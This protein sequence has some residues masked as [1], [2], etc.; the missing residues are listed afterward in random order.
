MIELPRGLAREFRAVLR[1]CRTQGR[2]REPCPF[3]VCRGGAHGLT[4]TCEAGGVV[5]RHETEGRQAGEVIA[6]PATVL[7]GLEG[8]GRVP[9]RLSRTAPTKGVT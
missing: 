3:V 1:K 7:A 8:A 5:L 6:F 4:L 9:V 2:A